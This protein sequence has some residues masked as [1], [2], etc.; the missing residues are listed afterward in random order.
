MPPAT[1]TLARYGLLRWLALAL[2]VG[3]GLVLFLWYA[4]DTE[5]VGTPSALEQ[6]P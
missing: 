5:P 4:P 3:A 6:L 1:S 2:L